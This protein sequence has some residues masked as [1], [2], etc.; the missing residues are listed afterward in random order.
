M[1]KFRAII[2]FISLITFTLFTPVYGGTKGYAFEYKTIV[3]LYLNYMK[4]NLKGGTILPGGYAPYTSE[5][6]GF[7][8]LLAAGMIKLAQDNDDG[9]TLQAATKYFMDGYNFVE[10]QI[11]EGKGLCRWKF[12]AGPPIAPTPDGRYSATDADFYIATAEYLAGTYLDNSEVKQSGL[13]M[14]DKI[15]KYSGVY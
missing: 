10:G 3:S 12:D 15:W 1:K 8:M 4:A 13:T 14:I 11:S 7:Q 6:L 2:I 5:G 9:T